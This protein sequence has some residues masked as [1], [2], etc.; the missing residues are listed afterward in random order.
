VKG[1]STWPTAPTSKSNIGFE[2]IDKIITDWNDKNL[3]TQSEIEEYSKQVKEKYSFIKQNK[4]NTIENYNYI[5]KIRNIVQKFKEY[6]C[7]NR[8]KQPSMDKTLLEKDNKKQK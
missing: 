4:D 7:C 5:T 6:L 3:R 1:H 2:Y 8:K